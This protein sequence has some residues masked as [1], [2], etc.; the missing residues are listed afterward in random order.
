MMGIKLLAIRSA[1]ILMWAGYPSSRCE[2]FPL[3]GCRAKCLIFRFHQRH[4]W[5]AAPSSRFEQWRLK[6]RE[7]VRIRLKL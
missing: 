6:D 1:A 3:E 5:K 7:R 4:R 2:R